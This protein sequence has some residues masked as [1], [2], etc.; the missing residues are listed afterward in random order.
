MAI[1]VKLTISNTTKK[2]LKASTNVKE[3]T[4]AV[5]RYM[6]YFMDLIPWK[7]F[8]EHAKM[9]FAPQAFIEKTPLLAEAGVPVE[10][11]EPLYQ[12]L[13]ANYAAMHS[14]CWL[15]DDQHEFPHSLVEAVGGDHTVLKKIQDTVG[16][17]YACGEFDMAH[18]NV[19][20]N[21]KES[22]FRF[23]GLRKLG[24]TKK[25]AEVLLSVSPQIYEYV[26]EN[27]TVRPVVEEAVA[28][29]E[30]T[31]ELPEAETVTAVE[32][33]CEPE[34][35]EEGKLNIE[36]LLYTEAKTFKR[37][38]LEEKLKTAHLIALALVSQIEDIAREAGVAYK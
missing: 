10:V 26:S 25:E 34:T 36:Q 35:A 19:L 14:N 33:V 16:N 8:K 18:L 21:N 12:D 30:A 7:A 15:N 1:T 37:E 32:A 5:V 29:G 2:A 4:N 31:P 22:N 17:T 9:R 23:G 27:F 13:A 11:I 6:D 20:L 3:V 28:I 24:F 38:Q